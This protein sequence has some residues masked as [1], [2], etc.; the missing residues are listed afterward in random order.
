M[1]SD[2]AVVAARA[3]LGKDIAVGP[4]A[5]IDPEVTVGDGCEI[6]PHVVLRNGTELG[7][8]C[9][10]G[11]GVV[12]GEPPMDVAYQG[13]AT[14]VRIGNDN[15]FREYV[16]IHRATGIGTSTVIGNNNLIMPYSHIAHNC[17]IG[18][19]VTIANSCQLAGY[20]EVQDYAVLGGMTG[21]HQHVR[22]GAYAMLGACSYLAK[23]LPPYMLGA[24]IPFR[25]RGINR[26][27]LNRAGWDSERIRIL[28]E[29][30]R[31]VYRSRH[32]LSEALGTLSKRFPQSVEARQLIAFAAGSKR[33]IQLR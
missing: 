30:Y 31:I 2:L 13:E 16:T 23:D 3:R 5:L 10:L 9:R 21:I 4:F 20:V 28:R 18:S 32:N 26:V 33:G 14:G 6:G 27:G 8:K 17:R 12:I 1:I 19:R 29:I 7:S 25:V 15:D 24:G 22:V 11:P